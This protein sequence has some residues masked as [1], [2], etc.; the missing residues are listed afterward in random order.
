MRCFFAW[1]K[2]WKNMMEPLWQNF[3]WLLM[4]TGSL[5]IVERIVRSVSLFA[6]YM[7]L[8]TL[9]K[10]VRK[11]RMSI[12][13]TQRLWWSV[14]WRFPIILQQDGKM[15]KLSA[16]KMR[17]QSAI[18]D[19]L[20]VWQLTQSI[21]LPLF[22]LIFRQS[23]RQQFLKINSNCSELRWSSQSAVFIRMACIFQIFLVIQ[24]SR[25]HRSLRHFRRA[26]PP[27]RQRIW[28]ERMDSSSIT[29]VNL[30]EQRATIL[31]I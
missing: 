15:L 30:Q 9:K 6:M 4:M 11:V 10:K 13:M 25:V 29:R 8:P 7:E 31:Y 14:L 22:V 19:M 1:L 17:W 27:M 21:S 26:I 28:S 20:C 5:L 3:L 2:L 12:L 24:E 18:Y 23:F 16:R